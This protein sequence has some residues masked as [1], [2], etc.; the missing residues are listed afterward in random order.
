ME[1]WPSDA[2]SDGVRAQ[3]IIQIPIARHYLGGRL[4]GA[5]LGCDSKGKFA[6]RRS[7][8]RCRSKVSC[9]WFSEIDY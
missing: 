6:I 9:P 4:G 7:S 3:K 8:L 2:V 5:S 1:R